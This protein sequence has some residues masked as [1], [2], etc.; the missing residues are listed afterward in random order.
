MFLL[1]GDRQLANCSNRS[2]FKTAGEPSALADP[3]LCLPGI[4]PGALKPL[5]SGFDSIGD[6]RSM[7]IQT[8]NQPV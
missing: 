8:V 5:E 4:P 2:Q 1:S 7:W 3:A 6:I